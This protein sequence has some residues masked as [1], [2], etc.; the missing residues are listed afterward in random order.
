MFYSG[1]RIYLLLIKDLRPVYDWT[2]NT[3]FV[4]TVIE[5][6]WSKCGRVREA[7]PILIKLRAAV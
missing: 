5:K 4:V 2:V 3:I 7:T 1:I 6:Q